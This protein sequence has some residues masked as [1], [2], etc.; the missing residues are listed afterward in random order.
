[1]SKP[2][3]FVSTLETERLTMRRATL[4][5]LPFLVELHQDP[6]VTRYLGGDGSTR[7]PEE[8]FDWLQKT[9]RWYVADRVG[10]FVVELEGHPIGRAGLGLFEIEREPSREDG[11]YV[12]SW[13][14][15]SFP[16]DRPARAILEVGYTFRRS[17]WGNGYATE[18]ARA[19]YAYALGEYGAEEVH[20]MIHADNV[21][22][23]RV[24]EKNGLE[25]TLVVHLEGRPYALFSRS[26]ASKS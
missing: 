6:Q 14:R 13:G 5:D 10:Q 3:A 20:S 2:P 7:S 9:M 15:G 1:M 23:R 24:A 21:G 17:A 19:W 4:S 18:A 22:S 25:R 8:S 11:A 12:A 16:H 26:K